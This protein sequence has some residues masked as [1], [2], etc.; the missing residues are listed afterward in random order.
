MGSYDLAIRIA[1]QDL[2]AAKKQ[3]PIDDLKVERAKVVL[4]ALQHA[5]RKEK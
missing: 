5:Q 3:E 4:E 2:E 1:K